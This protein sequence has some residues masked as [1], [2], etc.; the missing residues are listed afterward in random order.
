MKPEVDKEKCIGCSTCVPFCPEAA[1]DMKHETRDMKQ[2]NK[3]PKADIDYEYCKGCGVCAEVCP[4]KAI[5]MRK[6]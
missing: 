4:V 2:K 6:K 3:K 1:I 5:V